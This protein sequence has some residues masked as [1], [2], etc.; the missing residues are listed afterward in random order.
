VKPFVLLLACV[1]GF[2]TIIPGECPS[3]APLRTPGKHHIM[4][5][6]ESSDRL[7]TFKAALR[8]TAEWD[9]TLG[10]WTKALL[11]D[12]KSGPMTLRHSTIRTGLKKKAALR[13]EIAINKKRRSVLIIED[14]L[15][16]S[17]VSLGG[18]VTLRGQV[19][20]RVVQLLPSDFT[21]TVDLLKDGSLAFDF[22]GRTVH[23]LSGTLRL[24]MIHKKA[25]GIL[26]NAGAELPEGLIGLP[27]P[28]AL[29]QFGQAKLLT[30][31]RSYKAVFG[32]RIIITRD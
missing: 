26:V 17:Q 3:F 14:K 15:G 25:E 12:D 23:E 2:T 1:L 19:G 22:K 6:V 5:V 7:W 16:P 4:V 18:H 8:L 13:E 28:L 20:F 21:A 30:L 11:D 24:E 10:K 27:R 32:E 29:E 31:P 9:K